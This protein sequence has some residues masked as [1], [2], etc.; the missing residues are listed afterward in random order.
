[1]ATE[2]LG[3]LAMTTSIHE[4]GDLILVQCLPLTLDN[5]LLLGTWT[6]VA[7]NLWT[8]ELALTREVT[9]EAIKIATGTEDDA[10]T[11]VVLC[12]ESFARSHSKRIC[13]TALHNQIDSL[14]TIS[15]KLRR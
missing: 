14:H 11:R 2:T 7:A 6:T 9:L 8:L 15:R 4:T 5:S 3:I 10:A 12:H 13:E 1:M